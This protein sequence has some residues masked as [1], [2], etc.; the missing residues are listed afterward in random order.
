MNAEA[1]YLT[2]DHIT[3]SS[4]LVYGNKVAIISWT[5]NPVGFVLIDKRVADSYRTYFKFM[6]KLA[7]S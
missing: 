7:K 1:R 6:W 2:E 5:K 4:T 3:L